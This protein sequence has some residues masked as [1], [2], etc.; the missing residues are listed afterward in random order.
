[1]F[2]FEGLSYFRLWKNRWRKWRWEAFWGESNDKMNRVRDPKGEKKKNRKIQTTFLRIVDYSKLIII[3]K[4]SSM[5]RELKQKGSRRLWVAGSLIASLAHTKETG[6]LHLIR[7]AWLQRHL[8][9]DLKNV[10][11]TLQGMEGQLHLQL[12]KTGKP[13]RIE[14][15]RKGTKWLVTHKGQ[16]QTQA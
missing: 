13:I 4:K 9:T 10:S 11:W 5:A 3:S 7:L 16:L 14:A 15:G 12:I 2:Q 6:K 8:R 1:M